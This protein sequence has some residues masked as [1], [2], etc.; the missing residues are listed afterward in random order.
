VTIV[1]GDGAYDFN[2]ALDAIKGVGPTDDLQT[3]EHAEFGAPEYSRRVNR[4]RALMNAEG[5]DAVLATQEENVR[6]F[7]GYLTMLW[8]S[9]FRP[10]VAVLPQEGPAALVVSGQEVGNAN[11]TSWIE[12][13]APFPPQEPPVAFIVRELVSRGLTK[14]RIG[15]ELGFG[16]RTGMSYHQLHELAELLP[17][18]EIVDAT[19]LM[20]SVR[21][22]KSP[23]EISRL[24]RAADISSSGVAAAWGALRE[25]QTEREI[26]QAIGSSIFADGAEMGTH[27]SFFAVMA[28]D[29][30]QLSNAVASGY[31]LRTGDSV[32][33]DGG[34]SYGGY[35]C[36]FIRHASLGEPA[37]EHR[38]WYD[39]SVA[40]TEAAIEAIRPGVEARAVYDVGID[41]L[42]RAG[43]AAHNRMNIIGHGIG[44]DVHELPWVGD[45]TVFTADT[46]LHEGMVLCIEPG[47]SPPAASALRSQFIVEEEVEVTANGTNLLTSCLDK[48]I[49]VA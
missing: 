20:Q 1:L 21:M 45:E 5:M 28:G 35:A 23:E 38:R 22:L 11:L 39:A 8:V 10:V 19:P 4:L 25:G 44:A 27:R 40:A 2:A 9:R 42:A 26:L 29:R 30:W 33:V 43:F 36:D 49:W 24:R 18:A 48:E 41:V 3:P 34:A 46:I 32:V 13:A 37:A 15:I 17:D 12:E 31:A 47:T 6:Y 7:S 14:G 16:Q